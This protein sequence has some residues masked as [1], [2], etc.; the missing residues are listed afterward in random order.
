V[1]AVLVEQDEATGAALAVLDA[2]N[3]LVTAPIA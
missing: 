2:T 3:R 1:G